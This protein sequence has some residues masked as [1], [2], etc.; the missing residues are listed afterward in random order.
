MKWGTGGINIDATRIGT[1]E[2]TVRHRKEVNN[3]SGWERGYKKAYQTGGTQGRFPA[4]LIL[5]YPE[6]EYL[7]KDNLTR[8]QKDKLY[9]WLNEN[10]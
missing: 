1:G 9:K 6:N 3:S 4:N 2:S 8:E 10:T 7:C 5:S